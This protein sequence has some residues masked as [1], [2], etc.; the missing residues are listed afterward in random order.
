MLF[1][2]IQIQREGY[3]TTDLDLL[4]QG[5]LLPVKLFS[6]EL[7][8]EIGTVDVFCSMQVCL[9]ILEDDAKDTC[10]VVLEHIYG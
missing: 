1:I 2:E 7:V 9:Q 3:F 5:N 10:H 6:F 8:R 4:G